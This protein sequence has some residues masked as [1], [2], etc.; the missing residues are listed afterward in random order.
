MNNI[1]LKDGDWRMTVV[2]LAAG[3]ARAYADTIYTYQVYFEWIPYNF[4]IKLEDKKYEP[5]KWDEKMIIPKLK[6]I[7]SWYDELPHP[8]APSLDYIKKL[9]EGLWEFSVREQYND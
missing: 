7:C 6:S 4:K 5:V 8:F 2:C 1:Q 9:D 3:Q